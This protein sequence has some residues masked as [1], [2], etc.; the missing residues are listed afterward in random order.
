MTKTIKNN[1]HLYGG[2]EGGGTKFV[3]AVGTG[4]NDIRA[5]ARF[6]TTTP[7]E[8]LAQA[9]DFFKAQEVNFGKLAGIGFACFGPLDPNPAS[10]TYGHILPTPK[11][12]WS[13]AD[14][15]GILKKSFDIPIAFDTDVNGAALG[16]WRWGKAQGLKT[17]IYLTVGTGVG[18]GA[19]VEGNLLHGLLHP[20]M[21]HITVKHNKETDPFEGICPF[22]GDCLEGLASGVAIEQRWGQRGGTLP[23]E[24]PAWELEADY[25]AQALANYALTLS[26]QRIIVGGGVGSLGHLMP[27]VQKKTRDYINGYIQS[28]VIL[29]N[30][31]SYIVSPGLG[32]RSGM[33]G[34]IAL[35]EQAV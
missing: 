32:N 34:A 2:I 35:A 11:P 16:E 30:I 18:G 29:E 21:G 24:H 12:G 7:E 28:P 31:E 9:V 5:E 4:P 19:Y 17:F 1:N 33:L 3:C 25:I 26:P 8:T 6:P 14:V 22:H 13:N 20:E 10:K 27:K 15:V 23:P